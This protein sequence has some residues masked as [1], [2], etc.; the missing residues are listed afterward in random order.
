[1][2]CGNKD[3]MVDT[4]TRYLEYKASKDWISSDVKLENSVV[5][6]PCY[7]GRNVVLRNSVIGPGV[8][9]GDGAIVES[10]VIKNSIVMPSAHINHANI[11]NSMIGS[12]ARY[13]GRPADLSLGDY[14]VTK[15]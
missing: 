9:I 2:D 14:S 3:A 7:I 6:E 15:Q 5:I 12:H 10:S 8:S 13:T 11:V 1:M 4:N